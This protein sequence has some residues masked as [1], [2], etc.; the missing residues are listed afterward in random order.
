MRGDSV[1]SLFDISEDEIDLREK[2]KNKIIANRIPINATVF[3]TNNCN[4]QC[5]HCYVQSQKNKN[6]LPLRIGE[7]EKLLRELK[8]NGCIYLTIS[9][10]EALSALDFLEFYNMAY[11][12]NFQIRIISNL[13]LLNEKHKR[14]FG[15][16]KPNSIIVSLYGFSDKTYSEFCDVQGVFN[17]IIYNIKTLYE[18]GLN[19]ELQTVV[20]TMNYNEISLMNDF[21]NKNHIKMSFYRNITCEIDGNARPLN[22]QI[23]ISQELE[24]Y[25]ILCDEDELKQAIRTN[26]R[27]WDNGYKRCFAGLTNCYIDYQGNMFLCNHMQ[28]IK[29]SLLE[30]G[31]GQCWESMYQLR[32]KYIEKS[33]PCSNC[34]KRA[35]CGKC[36]PAFENLKKSFKFPFPECHANDELIKNLN[37]ELDNNERCKV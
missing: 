28:D 25:K 32:K 18:M 3:L 1:M 27:M 37:L 6:K 36:T 4:F 23:S 5:K 2:F 9:G 33:N 35:L 12:L 13:S 26:N 24:S 22:Y 31:F 10:G 30:E 34:K 16:K 7:W 21:A 8:H 14:L 20:N 15:S 17:K 19:V 11:D 29:V